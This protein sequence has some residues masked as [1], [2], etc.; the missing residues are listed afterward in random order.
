MGFSKGLKQQL[1]PR[2]TGETPE[3][4]GPKYALNCDGFNETYAF[5]IYMYPD[6]FR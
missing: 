2:L 5:E 6:A 4:L 1:T 3:V